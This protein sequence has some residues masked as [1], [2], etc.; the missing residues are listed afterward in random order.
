MSIDAVIEM[1]ISSLPCLTH[2]YVISIVENILVNESC[3]LFQ[4]KEY[5]ENDPSE[6][7][8]PL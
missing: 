6:I 2:S 4:T 1:I 7:Y 3:S 8:I 5:S